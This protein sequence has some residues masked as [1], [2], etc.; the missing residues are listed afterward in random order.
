MG[1]NVDCL[2]L[3]SI[4]AYGKAEQQFND[5]FIDWYPILMD[6]TFEGISQTLSTGVSRHHSNARMLVMC[7]SIHIFI[8]DL[9]Y[10]CPS[11][12]VSAFCII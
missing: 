8:S 7:S 6:K 1:V 3:F 4:T 11:H 10:I 9:R 2:L 12:T 5:I